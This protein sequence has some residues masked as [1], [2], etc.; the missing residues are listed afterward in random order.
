MIDPEFKLYLFGIAG[1]YAEGVIAVAA[2]SDEK[3]LKLAVSHYDDPNNRLKDVFGKYGPPDLKHCEIK[4]I[5]E[6]VI[7]TW[8][9]IE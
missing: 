9:Y 7:D 8:T 6:G 5:Q 1:D 2:D 4:P 3:A